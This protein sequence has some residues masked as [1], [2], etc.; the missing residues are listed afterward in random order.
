MPKKKQSPTSELAEKLLAVLEAQR[1]LGKDAYPLTLQRLIQLTEPQAP[2]ELIE[3]AIGSKPFKD[4]AVVAL[5]SNLAAPVALIEDRD[6]LAASPVLLELTLASVCTPQKP[7]AAIRTLKTKLESRL[8]Q[9]FEAAV[10][11][12]IQNNSLPVGVECVTFGKAQ[13]LH[14]RNLP[15]PQQ[16]EVLLAEKFLAV[17]DAQRR[18]GQEA[19]PMSL[20]R[21]IELTCPQAQP[22]LV[23]KA[24][25][26]S[27]LKDKLALVNAKKQEAPVAL[28]EDRAQLV[29]SNIFLE[30]LL[31]SK[32]KSMDHVFPVD[33]LLPQKSDLRQPFLEAVNRRIER[34]SLPATMGWLWAGKKKRVFFLED[35]HRGQLPE[36]HI[37][38][39]TPA[40]AV[41]QPELSVEVPTDFAQTFDAAF[42]RIDR[43]NGAHNFVNLVELRRQMRLGRQSFDAELRKLRLAGRYTLSAAEGRH[44]ASPEEREAG[45]V[46]DGS[47]LLYV[48]RKAP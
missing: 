6:Q 13:H 48:S 1:A 46:E 40:P 26:H 38:G 47:L 21:L 7:T 11:Q 22:K 14:P 33:N 17:L 35:V 9:A 30:Y 28:A 10:A 15:L 45:I 32:R 42:T 2:S 39:S 36:D 4:Q 31:R 24:L 8:K 5:K 18:L 37:P 25:A 44:G 27:T 20:K 41:M 3:K 23:A 43:Q 12:Q 34:G 16:P 19:Y 29:S